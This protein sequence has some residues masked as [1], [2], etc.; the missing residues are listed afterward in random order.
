MIPVSLA[1]F[2]IRQMNFTRAIQYEDLQIGHS[3]PVVSLQET[4][5]QV[6]FE[7]YRDHE[8]Q[9]RQSNRQQRRR[10]R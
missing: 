3:V 6:F 8:R 10:Q 7:L 4:F 2:V 1:E 9:K 5:R